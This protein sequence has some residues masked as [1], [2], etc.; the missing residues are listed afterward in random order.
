[1]PVT[2]FDVNRMYLNEQGIHLFLGRA[3]A[4]VM[5]A[6]WEGHQRLADIHKHMVVEYAP[7]A[8]TTV[9]TT[10]FRLVEKGYLTRKRNPA[11]RAPEYLYT[12]TLT[13]H[14]FIA[15]VVRKVVH[16]LMEEYPAET[17]LA[18]GIEEASR[19]GAS[20]DDR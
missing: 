9:S 19:I 16:K 11:T 15:A 12:A 10:A 17:D 8:F 2:H 6:V 18:I 4:A 14:Q 3:E 1:M 7:V 13:G 20:E 5:Q